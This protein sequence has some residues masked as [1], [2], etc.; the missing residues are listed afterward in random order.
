MSLLF[1]MRLAEFGAQINEIVKVTGREAGEVVRQEGK[2]FVQDAMRMTPPFSTGPSTESLNLQRKTG[3]NAVERDIRKVFQK[4]DPGKVRDRRIR[5][6][7]ERAIRKRDFAGIKIILQYLKLPVADVLRE[8]DPAIHDAKRDRRGRVQRNKN[9]VWI[10]NEPSLNRLIRGKKSHVGKAK[11]G[12]ADAARGL[13][14]N[15]PGWIT[16]HSS[17][18]EFKDKTKDPVRPSIVVGNAVEYIQAKGAQLNIINR[19]LANR[20]RNM[21]AKLEKVARS[22]W[23]KKG[24][25]LRG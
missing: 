19:A 16:R 20:I 22:G 5:K 13:G 9:K 6:D 23:K 21:K 25:T 24:L 17:P 15:L 12:W 11:A 4:I 1:K 8:A 18:G 14:L 2:L 3:E 10:L 7:L